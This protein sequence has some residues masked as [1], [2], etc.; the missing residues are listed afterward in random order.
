MIYEDEIDISKYK[1]EY[2][3]E[4]FSK[5]IKAYK[6]IVIGR[7]GV[8]KTTIINRLMKKDVDGEYDPTMSIDIKNIQMK[9]NDKIIQIQIWDCCGSDKYAQNT[10]N[11][12][13]NS[14]IS[15]LVYAINDKEKSFENLDNWYNILKEHSY[16]SI[17]FLIGNK[18]DLEKEREVTIEDAEK[19]KNNHDGIKIFLETSALYHNNMDNMDKLLDYIAISIFEKE[20]KDENKVDNE[21]KAGRITLNKE[22]FT[23]IKERDK[24]K[25]R[26]CC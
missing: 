14:Y 1:I 19:Y 25:K 2:I 11:L 13:K 7:Y 22:D 24:K 21:M 3:G 17:K 10:P 15:L 4:K 20:I 12:F 18:N 9:V 8:G 5:E 16:D 23:K 26:N 6:V